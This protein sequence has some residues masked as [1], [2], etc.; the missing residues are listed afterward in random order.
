M[1][2]LEKHSKPYDIVYTNFPGRIVYED[3]WQVAV[4]GDETPGRISPLSEAHLPMYAE[5]IRQSFA[6]EAQDFRLTKENCP[7][8]TSFTIDE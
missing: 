7:G 4:Y 1:F 5:V 8:H 2:V 3:K 6:T